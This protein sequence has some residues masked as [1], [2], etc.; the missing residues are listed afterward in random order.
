MTDKVQPG[1]E[2]EVTNCA[3]SS[4]SSDLLHSLLNPEMQ[5]TH[6]NPFCSKYI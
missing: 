4:F 3:E 2:S 1:C 6:F 5:R